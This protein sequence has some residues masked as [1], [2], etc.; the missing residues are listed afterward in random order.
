M[1]E[2]SYTIVPTSTPLLHAHLTYSD[3]ARLS[4]HCSLFNR[5]Y[6]LLSDCS[7]AQPS[8]LGDVITVHG[9][10]G[11]RRDGSGGEQSIEIALANVPETFQGE[12]VDLIVFAVYRLESSSSGEIR[13]W[14]EKEKAI[15]HATNFLLDDDSNGIVLASLARHDEGWLVSDLEDDIPEGSMSVSTQDESVSTNEFG[16]VNAGKGLGDDPQRSRV[17]VS[18]PSKTAA[19]HKTE[20]CSPRPSLQKMWDM[21][22]RNF[23]LFRDHVRNLEHN[24]FDELRAL[25]QEL[26]HTNVYIADLRQ[27]IAKTIRFAADEYQYYL[28]VRLCSLICFVSE[29]ITR[30]LFICTSKEQIYIYIYCRL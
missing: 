15:I 18:G 24:F 26:N 22:R 1:V 25:R 30:G 20:A 21:E 29:Y 13:F 5:N 9:A 10:G 7:L 3:S 27:S 23:D 17:H 12:V 6:E 4:L 19:A 11:I 8:L 28:R 2:S 14:L 16:N